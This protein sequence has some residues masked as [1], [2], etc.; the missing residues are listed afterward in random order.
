MF[1]CARVITA[2]RKGK[3]STETSVPVNAQQKQQAA[4]E[5]VK[6][7]IPTPVSVYVQTSKSVTNFRRSMKTLANVSVRRWSLED[8]GDVQ[9]ANQVLPVVT[10][11]IVMAM[12]IQI[13]TVV[14]AVLKVRTHQIQTRQIRT[15]QILMD[16]IQMVGASITMATTSIE[17]GTT[18]VT[19][20]VDLRGL[21][22]LI[23]LGLS[24]LSGQSLPTNV[25]Q[26]TYMSTNIHVTA[27]IGVITNIL[28]RWYHAT[29]N[30]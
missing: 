10:H 17:A 12:M 23:R 25:R 30:V 11:Q 20:A 18:T 22:V 19:M 24:S 29:F 5:N 2:V 21:V 27:F 13:R 3:F 6:S 14:M 1:V 16:Q 4:V 7:W 9:F 28:I 8:A 26:Q 15:H